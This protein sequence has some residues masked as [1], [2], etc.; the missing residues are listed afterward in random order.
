MVF[1]SDDSVVPARVLPDEQATLADHAMER[2]EEE[3]AKVPDVFWP[4]P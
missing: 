2:L 4:Q 1:V 3:T